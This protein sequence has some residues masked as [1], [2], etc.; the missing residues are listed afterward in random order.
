MYIAIK[1]SRWF[2]I[3]FILLAYACLPAMAESNLNQSDLVDL[4]LS[5]SK[6]H[7]LS[8]KYLPADKVYLAMNK[9][10][11]EWLAANTT[12][13]GAVDRIVEKRKYNDIEKWHKYF[14][15]GTILMAGLTAISSSNESFHE[16]TAYLTAGGAVSSVVTGYLAHS[17][18]FDMKNGLFADDN[19]HIILGTLGAAILTTAVITA[20]GGDESSHSGM[21]I[22]GGALMTLGLIKIKW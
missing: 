2:L 14:G 19:L 6:E 20:D 9:Q 17:S 3:G 18:R 8:L 13:H 5:S 22:T 1:L 15:Y 10:P 7:Q 16:A 11:N 12:N 4:S 21:G